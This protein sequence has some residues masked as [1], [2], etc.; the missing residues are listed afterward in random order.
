MIVRALALGAVLGLFGT[1]PFQCAHDPDPNLRREDT[2][3][4]ALWSLA[5]KFKA[6]HNDAA[7]KETL[8]FLVDKYPSNRHAAAARE[9][10][11]LDGGA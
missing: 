6:E 1:A 3:G 2:A 8:R 4:D 11:G 5:E 9:E 10:L 7:A